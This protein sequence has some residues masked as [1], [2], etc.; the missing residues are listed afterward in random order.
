MF[1]RSGLINCLSS[2]EMKA[3]IESKNPAIGKVTFV[4][5]KYVSSIYFL[6]NGRVTITP[7]ADLLFFR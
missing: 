1:G 7:V 6:Y 3:N 2:H 4:I 5:L